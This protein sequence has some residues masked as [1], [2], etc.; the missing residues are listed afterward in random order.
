MIDPMLIYL[1]LQSRVRMKVTVFWETLV[2]VGTENTGPIKR[3]VAVAVL[4]SDAPI[5]G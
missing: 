5:V 1:P 3:R 4:P 2:R